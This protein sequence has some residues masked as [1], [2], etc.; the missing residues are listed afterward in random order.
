MDEITRPVIASR[1]WEELRLSINEV[2]KA[3]WKGEIPGL[4]NEPSVGIMFGRAQPEPKIKRG[5]YL[6]YFL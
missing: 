6:E 2:G 5:A 3:A 1:Y 4:S